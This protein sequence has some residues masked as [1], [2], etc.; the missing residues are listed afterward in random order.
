MEMTRKLFALSTPV[1]LLLSLS[2]QVAPAPSSNGTTRERPQS[3]RPTQATIQIGSSIQIVNPDIP[4]ELRDKT[5]TSVFSGTLT[6]M[7]MLIDVAFAG[8]NPELKDAG[9]D[10]IS[11]WRYTPCTADG[12]PIDAQVY[13]IISS[14]HGSI[15]TSVEVDP[16]Y[17]TEPG[18]PIEEQI[19]AGEIFR[20]EPGYVE[21]PRPTFAPDPE[22]SELARKAKYQ[23]T[24][25]MGVIVGADGTLKD[26]WVTKK[27]GLGLDQKSL[28]V[29]RNW[30]FQP[31]TKNGVPVAVLVHIETQFNLF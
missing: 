27:A 9:L 22:Y 12:K 24:C 21:S 8:G 25:V 10:A 5:L 14:N 4:E 3:K 13:I 6:T 29:V 18:K 20:V 1:F 31:G 2:A 30:K 19:S 23:G 28:E 26:V 15:S 16:P 11:Q 17:P 7:G